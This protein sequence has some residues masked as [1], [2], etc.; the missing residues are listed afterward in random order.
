MSQ[1]EQA[2]IQQLESR[3]LARSIIPGFLKNLASY[4]FENPHLNLSEANKKL[5]YLGWEEIQLDYH[6]FQMA[7]TWLEIEGLKES[8]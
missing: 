8:I 6:T 4:F 1:L 2:L 7:I 3:G 5:S